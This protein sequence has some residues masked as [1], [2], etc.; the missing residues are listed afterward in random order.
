MGELNGS[1][2]QRSTWIDPANSATVVDGEHSCRIGGVHP[3]IA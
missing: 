3:R 2:Q 1:A